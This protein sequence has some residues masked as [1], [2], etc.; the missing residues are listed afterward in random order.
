M[1][2]SVDKWLIKR[3]LY[4]FIIDIMHTVYSLEWITK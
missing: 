3:V 2:G 1:Q 4:E